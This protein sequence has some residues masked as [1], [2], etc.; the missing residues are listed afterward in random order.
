MLEIKTISILEDVKKDLKRFRAK[1]FRLRRI[2]KILRNKKQFEGWSDLVMIN[3]I[4]LG[5][6]ELNLPFSKKEV[7]SAFKLVNKNDYYPG[8]K[9]IILANLLKNSN[10]YSV[11]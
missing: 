10:D 6:E 11:F 7:Y 2:F 1:K 5:L 4:V 9:K 8:V 3:G